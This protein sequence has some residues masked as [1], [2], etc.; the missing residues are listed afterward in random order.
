MSKHLYKTTIFIIFI[1]TTLSISKNSNKVNIT[2][3]NIINHRTKTS[4]QKYQ[5]YVNYGKKKYPLI[6]VE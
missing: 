1:L 4:L 5:I 6:I 2:I 3:N